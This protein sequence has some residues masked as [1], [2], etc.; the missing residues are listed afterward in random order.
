MTSCL[1]EWESLLADSRKRLAVFRKMSIDRRG[2]LQEPLAKDADEVEDEDK[3]DN[4]LDWTAPVQ[5]LET[6]L[7]LASSTALEADKRV[8]ELQRRMQAE[9]AQKVA[10]VGTH[11]GKE[12]DDEEASLASKGGALASSLLPSSLSSLDWKDL[13]SKADAKLVQVLASSFG[14]AAVRGR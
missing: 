7:E 9:M 8:L 1:V 5:E 4:G 2:G 10:L 14:N 11:N 3:D 12:D 13:Q 6:T